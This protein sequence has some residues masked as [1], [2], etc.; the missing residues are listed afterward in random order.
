MPA[1][2]GPCGGCPPSTRPPPASARELGEGDALLTL[3][4]GDVDRVAAA[5]VEG[6]A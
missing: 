5:L 4:A 3:G 1:A 6:D 2:A